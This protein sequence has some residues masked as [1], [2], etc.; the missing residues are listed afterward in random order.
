MA[1][2]LDV[3]SQPLAPSFDELLQSVHE[4]GN[5][6]PE[7]TDHQTIAMPAA[8]PEYPGVESLSLP[9]SQSCYKIPKSVC[10]M[11]DEEP[12]QTDYQTIDM[13]A[14]IFATEYANRPKCIKF[15][16]EEA[17]YTLRRNQRRV[18]SG[19]RERDWI[20]HVAQQ[21]GIVIGICV[22]GKPTRRTP[23]VFTYVDM[24]HRLKGVGKSL[25][26]KAQCMVT[27]RGV[28]SVEL[29]ACISDARKFYCKQAGFEETPHVNE[30]D[31]ACCLQWEVD[32]GLAGESA[33]KR[34]DLRQDENV[35]LRLHKKRRPNPPCLEEVHL[36]HFA[37]FAASDDQVHTWCKVAGAY[38][39]SMAQQKRTAQKYVSTDRMTDRQTA[40]CKMSAT[41]KQVWDWRFDITSPKFEKAPIAP[42]SLKEILEQIKIMYPIVDNHFEQAI[43]QVSKT[44]KGKLLHEHQDPHHGPGNPYWDLVLSFSLQGEVIFT[45]V[46]SGTRN[47]YNCKAGTVFAMSNTPEDVDDGLKACCF[48]AD[49]KHGTTASDTERVVL[50]VR[51]IRRKAALHPGEFAG[52]RPEDPINLTISED[53][54]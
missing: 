21:G 42:E 3:E 36:P 10:E 45:I 52:A 54:P 8:E 24:Q 37:K 40:I 51:Y 41:C 19:E 29:Q 17:Y 11:G 25:I 5:A 35:P 12:E 47:K 18:C 43:I 14:N 22:T 26:R 4:M 7:Q 31:D 27:G 38:L 15:L 6:E 20:A 49:C 34:A 32:N 1:G 16:P 33:T 23:I 9:L 44:P 2:Y 39:K 13:P 50:L 28:L 48:P 46:T 53:E 30:K